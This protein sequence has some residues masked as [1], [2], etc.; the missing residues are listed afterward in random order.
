MHASFLKEKIVRA[1]QS[2]KICV[3]HMKNIHLL[4]SQLQL[5]VDPESMRSAEDS[6]CASSFYN[7]A[8]NGDLLSV[9]G[10]LVTEE[11]LK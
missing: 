7:V 6:D 2:K 1:A 8:I 4:R 10:E 11:L 5:N 3:L 9:H